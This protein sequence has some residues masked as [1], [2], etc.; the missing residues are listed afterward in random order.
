[1]SEAPQIQIEQLRPVWLF[2]DDLLRLVDMLRRRGV[3]EISTPG[4]IVRI[5]E[6]RRPTDINV[7]KALR[8]G[9]EEV[10]QTQPMRWLC[11]LVY[12]MGTWIVLLPRQ[13]QVRHVHDWGPAVLETAWFEEILD[14]IKVR[15]HPLWF[16]GE[17]GWQLGVVLIASALFL[18]V[19][20]ASILRGAAS[21]ILHILSFPGLFIWAIMMV[22]ALAGRFIPS[23]SRVTLWRWTRQEFSQRMQTIAYYV[24]GGGGALLLSSFIGSRGLFSGH[25]LLLLFG[26]VIF[27]AAIIWGFGFLV[28]RVR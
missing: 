14:F 10:Y 23:H 20:I 2:F 7:D 1:M 21:D 28:S 17:R 6:E 25:I 5:P 19:V 13:A 15:H 4:R 9:C 22:P 3:V 16:L 27:V 8:Q 12:E 26:L 18:P 11:L 24:I